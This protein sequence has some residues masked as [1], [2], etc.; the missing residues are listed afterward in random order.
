M[1]KPHA[2]PTYSQIPPALTKNKHSTT[3]DVHMSLWTEC[4]FGSPP[5]SR[6]QA[7]RRNPGVA[8]NVPSSV[9][10]ETLETN[11]YVPKL[12]HSAERYQA[13]SIPHVLEGCGPVLFKICVFSTTLIFVVPQV[14]KWKGLRG[15]R[16]V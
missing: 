7:L 9:R 1:S 10:V 3:T 15:R 4:T 11:P 16:P 5:L 12:L 13:F 6:T 2:M 8:N 14:G